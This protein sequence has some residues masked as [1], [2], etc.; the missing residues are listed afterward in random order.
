MSDPAPVVPAVTLRR[1]AA[2]DLHR[3]WEI[4]SAPDTAG[5]LGERSPDWHAGALGDPD[6]EHLLVLDR[7]DIVGFVVLAAPRG[8]EEGVELR[9]LAIAP[10]HRG[11]G[12]GR[13]ALRAVLRHVFDSAAPA[14]APGRVDRV[15]LDVKPANVRA[16]ALY[17]GEGFVREQELPASPGEP[18][19]PVALVIL[20]RHRDR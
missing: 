7:G 12:L 13:A 18:D 14:G 17:T 11:R 15:W 8:T 6:R 2:D 1:T 3:V 5:W 4:E 19:G 10:Q 9:R 16:L 20:A